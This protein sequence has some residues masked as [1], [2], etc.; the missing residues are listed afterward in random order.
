MS[1]SPSIA[2]VGAGLSGLLLARYL[3]CN[4]ISCTI[5]EREASRSSRA[6]GGS[7]DLHSDSGLIAMKG[8]GLLEEFRKLSRPE[9]DQMR[10]L[11]KDGKVWFDDRD[12]AMR[13]MVG[14]LLK[15]VGGDRPEIDRTDLRN[16]LIDSL[17]LGTIRWD[18]HFQFAEPLPSGSYKL[19]F[20]NA[21]PAETDILIGADGTWSRVRPLLTTVLPVYTGVSF[22]EVVITDIDTNHPALAEL[23][24]KGSAM[25]MG[26]GKGI[27]PQRNSRGITRVY[28]TVGRTAEDWLEENPLP[29]DP[30]E[31]RKLLKSFFQPSFDPSVLELIDVCDD[32][33]MRSWKIYAMP[34]GGLD[35]ST[36]KHKGITLIGDAAHVMS[37]FA[38]EGANLALIDAYDLGKALVA[39]IKGK[40][41]ATMDKVDAGLRSFEKRMLKRA[42]A[43]AQESQYNMELLYAPEAPKEFIDLFLVYFPTPMNLLRLGLQYTKESLDGWYGY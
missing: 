34:P 31:A 1:S 19:H 43:S 8:A 3:Q 21:S 35:W 11:D 10:I 40:E 27:M 32:A 30:T 29:D 18:H 5:Y 9:D 23:A 37:P 28:V 4:S 39:T 7:L 15:F 33:P 2:I 13:R 36:T 17:Q 6:Q 25:I 14:S 12:G 42:E 41:P 20:A 16:I 26:D 22:F 38:G 24:G